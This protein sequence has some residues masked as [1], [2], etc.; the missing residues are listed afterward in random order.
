MI[1]LTKKE[2]HVGKIIIVLT[3][4]DR[5]RKTVLDLRNEINISDIINEFN[6]DESITEVHLSCD[7]ANDLTSSEIDDFMKR[8]N[9]VHDRSQLENHEVNKEETEPDES[10]EFSETNEDVSQNKKTGT[11]CPKCGDNINLLYNSDGDVVSCESCMKID[12]YQAGKK[13]GYELAVKELESYAKEFEKGTQ[14]PKTKKNS[15]KGKT[16]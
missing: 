11:C 13:K 14:K 3:K 5:I 12:A 9:M 16:K 10:N 1:S 8:C 7:Y 4:E 2:G 6:H 15:R